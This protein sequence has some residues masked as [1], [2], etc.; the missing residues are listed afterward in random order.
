M[1]KWLSIKKI[2]LANY[3]W[4]N[5]E[6]ELLEKIVLERLNK[7]DS[8][9]IKDWKEISQELYRLNE[10]DGK[11]YRNAKQCKEHWNCHL[12]PELKKGLWQPEEDI[13]L[14]RFIRDNK[15]LKKWSELS[16]YFDGR[17]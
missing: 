11:V 3:R 7:D 2:T 13:K 4:L 12:N 8:S 5:D 6:S 9:S 10:D 16:K 17:T 1:F 14:L 15:G